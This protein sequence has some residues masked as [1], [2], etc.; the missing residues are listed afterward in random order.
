MQS[1]SLILK[2]NYMKRDNLLSEV[3][4][5]IAGYEGKYVISSNGRIKSFTAK[6]K[7]ALMSPSSGMRG[8]LCVNLRLNGKRKFCYVHRLVLETFVGPCPE[9][10]ECCHNDGNHLN[11]TLSNLRWDTKSSNILDQ[12][13]HG[14][15]N[16][17]R[18]THCK[19][20]HEFTPEN[21][22]KNTGGL[23]RLCKTCNKD[24]KKKRMSSN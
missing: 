3:W 18:K 15:H 5:D 10:M 19:R 4:K 11:N 22:Y 9:G 17:A 20:G 1:L 16:M 21:T 24:N 14:V 12:V 23:G 13:Q 8:R 2:L 7:G 6:S